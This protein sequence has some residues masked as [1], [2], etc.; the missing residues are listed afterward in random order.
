MPRVI[1]E[2]SAARAVPAGPRV[3]V[4]GRW[5]GLPVVLVLS[6]CAA[7]ANAPRPAPP[8]PAPP[9]AAAPATGSL[10]EPAVRQQLATSLGARGWRLIGTT[11][12]AAPDAEPNLVFA[13]PGSAATAG[14]TVRV[15]TLTVLSDRRAANER[16]AAVGV[17][18]EVDCARGQF[19]TLGRATYRDRL[20]ADQIALTPITNPTAATIA[21]GSVA[22]HLQNLV[23]G[24]RPSSGSGVVI[25]PGRV[26]TNH[27][28]A[29]NCTQLQVV[30][31]GQR[32]PARLLAHD[33]RN[34]L[35]LLEATTVSPRGRG[36]PPLRRVPVTGENVMVAGFPLSGLLGND[37]VVTTGIVNSLAGLRNDP[38]QLQISAPVQPGNSGGPLLDRS[39]QLLGLVVSKL[40]VLRTAAA[41]GDIAQNV[42]FAIKP[43]VIRL[44]LGANGQPTR[45][46]DAGPR[47]EGEDLALRARDMTVKVECS[48][49]RPAV[50]GA[51]S[52]TVSR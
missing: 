22:F 16:A 42:N 43:E 29:Q 32:H 11:N 48:G 51:A 2:S 12:N 47:L 45:S 13:H 26:L 14:T 27:H 20:A 35:A 40:N 30:Q 17:Q 5:A 7:P 33:E 23:C 38:T 39:G 21:Q 37:I 10:A 49:S 44:F 31:E 52:P 36:A 25:A 3:S 46:V 15:W 4:R 1:A 8:A 41:T 6:A 24:T 28:V 50:A 18:S 9:G 34:D 19:R